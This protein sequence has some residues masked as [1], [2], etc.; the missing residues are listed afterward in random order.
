MSNT[1]DYS[2]KTT[3]ILEGVGLN[4]YSQ[5]INRQFAA[6][7]YAGLHAE[8]KYLPSKYLYNKRGDEIFQQIM[9]MEEY[10]PTR[11]EY[12]IFEMHRSEM[13]EHFSKNNVP[14]RLIEFG[15]GDGTKTKVLLRHFLEQQANFSYVPIDI[16][17][18]IIEELTTDLADNMPNL[19]VQGIQ[20]DY[21]R[22]IDQLKSSF[23]GQQVRNVVLFLGANIGNF[24]HQESI[25]F[26][27]E[28]AAHLSSG[29]LLMT[30]F[31]LKKEP[32]KILNAY[33]DKPGV[34]RA[35]KHNLL[36][37]INEELDANFNI[38]DFQYFPIYD[39][40]EGSIRSYLVSKK[41]QRVTISAIDEVIEFDAWEAIY[42]ER[43]QKYS[44][45]DI[46]S[47]ARDSGFSVVHHFY[48]SHRLFT[49]SLW[50]LS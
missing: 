13:L 19:V 45:G 44:V 24:A 21:F 2:E 49:D 35:F 4:G 7:V 34:T 36:L 12:E 6:D 42:M 32:E 8:E 18:N 25:L 23:N 15:A 11:A 37:R 29:D 31:D 14:F 39:P 3:A 33:F 50:Q 26:L 22:A 9:E 17:A 28:I 1:T 40:M 27:K 20:D 5:K 10:Y 41:E 38:D 48:D 43:S 30:G 16:S 47:L 46:E